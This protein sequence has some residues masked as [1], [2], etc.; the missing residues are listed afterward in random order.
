[1]AF[2]LFRAQARGPAYSQYAEK[3][4]QECQSHWENGRQQCE[5]ASLTGNP[6]KLPKHA[7]KE[8]LSGLIYKG[9]VKLIC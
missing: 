8:H 4:K 6:C 7:D 5:A 2:A 1:M 3:L 9:E